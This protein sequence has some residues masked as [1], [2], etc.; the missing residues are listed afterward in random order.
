MSYKTGFKNKITTDIERIQ[1]NINKN[2]YKEIRMCVYAIHKASKIPFIRFLFEQ[3]PYNNYL[4]LPFVWNRNNI[5]ENSKQHISNLL[6]T[7]IFILNLNENC[8]FEGFYEYNDVLYVFFDISNFEYIEELDNPNSNNNI[9]LLLLHE[10]L[11]EHKFCNIDVNESSLSFF[12]NNLPI[13][14]LYDAI[15]NEK[16]EIPI[17][18][19][20]GKSTISK[21]N[22]TIIF[23]EPAKDKTAIMGPY[24]YFTNFNGAI[25][26]GGWSPNYDEEFINGK[27]ITN[28]DGKYL[29]G[30]IVRF[31]LFTG[32]TKY[33]ENDPNNSNDESLISK[34]KLILDYDENKDNVKN[35]RE[36]LKLKIS[37][38]DGNWTK[39][40]DSIFLGNLELEDGSFLDEY[41]QYVLKDYHQQIPLSAHYI[42]KKTLGNKYDENAF[43]NI[44]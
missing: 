10:I 43:Y 23:G 25:R 29:N 31:A 41:I 27:C 36:Y 38:Y 34:Q 16:Y 26:Q 42:N 4:T 40:F 5:V 21:L 20:V 32:R 35:L 28:K 7:T 3:I 44:L 12:M 9:K 30:S 24:Y 19:Y 33:I 22:F 2:G 1:N 8:I 15:T 14:Y 18:A 17:V 11:C 6:N 39:Q 37:D 13:F